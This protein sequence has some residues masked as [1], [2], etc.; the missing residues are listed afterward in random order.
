MRRCYHRS[1][2]YPNASQLQFTSTISIGNRRD[3]LMDGTRANVAQ[4]QLQLGIRA[5]VPVGMEHVRVELDELWCSGGQ[6]LV[7]ARRVG[8][9]KAQTGAE[10]LAE[11][12]ARD[13]EGEQRRQRH[14]RDEEAAAQRHIKV[15][16]CTRLKIIFVQNCLMTPI[17]V[18]I[19]LAL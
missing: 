4:L 14:L 15:L 19:F 1:N 6:D 13:L 7:D 3:R 5:G 12:T 9:T 10:H 18:K 16:Q 17:N 11:W 2:E 8:E